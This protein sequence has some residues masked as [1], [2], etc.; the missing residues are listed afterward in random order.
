[1]IRKSLKILM[2]GLAVGLI[3]SLSFAVTGPNRSTDSGAAVNGKQLWNF[4]N[5]DL[6]TV[7]DAVAN[8]TGK[9][10][11][12]D[13]RVSGK[14]TVISNTPLDAKA[15]YQVF[16][17]A[18]D[19]AGFSAI[20]TGA[21]IKIV[22]ASDNRS[23]ASLKVK[24]LTSA[25][26]RVEVLAV[27]HVSAL[28][29][30]PVL[31][32]LLP[33]WASI[34][35]YQPSNSLV[36]TARSSDIERLKAILQRVDSPSNQ[37]VEY[38]PLHHALAQEVLDTLKALQGQNYSSQQ[39]LGLAA[40]LRGNAIL[41]S[42][43]PAKRLQMKVI[44]SEL[45]TPNPE[46]GTSGN[47]EVIRL[48]Y[49]RA[50]DI[51]PILAGIANARYGDKVGTTIG[52]KRRLI[53]QAASQSI[54]TSEE[55][56]SRANQ[57]SYERVSEAKSNQSTHP[58]VEIIA[59]PN[60]NSVILSAPRTLMRTL[61]TVIAKLDVRPTQIEVEALIAEVNEDN[62]KQLGIE[63]GSVTDSR[64]TTSGTSLTSGFNEGVG[65]ITEDGFANFQAILRALATSN[66]ADILS[67]PSV[68][69]LDN[70]PAKIQVG[71]QV[72]ARDSSYPSNAGGTTTATPFTTFKRLNVALHLFV[73]PQINEGSS[74][75]LTID[76]A[77]DTL[78]DPE[79][80]GED[81][82]INTSSI[83]TAVLVDSGDVLVLGGLSQNKVQQK[84]SKIPILGDIPV[85]RHAFRNKRK[86]HGK[87]KLL[88]FI[89][90]L[91]LHD[92]RDG[93]R[94]SRQHYQ[95][96]RRTQLSWLQKH[97]PHNADNET[98]LPRLDPLPKL[99]KPFSKHVK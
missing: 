43:S 99:P 77:N 78:Q 97:T 36:I 39:K 3:S 5:A 92:S 49:L 79:N 32:P 37:A 84:V 55:E 40:D 50:S 1:M 76:Q 54:N 65:I 96:F 66:K 64:F 26:A 73:T 22:P 6:A 51:V 12:L 27:K 28:Q 45:D 90:P 74:V 30:V 57:A 29:L 21:V 25:Q 87:R 42:G 17:A 83:N 52:V 63:W 44:I 56:G 16:L 34:S 69:V 33:Q 62:V 8:A 15:S 85:I 38:I 46:T 91:I 59:E 2:L 81:P 47:T 53:Q 31:R 20:D 35:A 72:S 14:V 11:V 94:I 98:L 75:K 60:T 23:E 58:L 70:H 80:P 71:T 48:H 61:K 86:T 88:I 68:V 82:I 19:L 67:T 13:P 4:R 41:L 7:I 18:L 9:N 93:S 89:R 24:Q 10:F 95:R